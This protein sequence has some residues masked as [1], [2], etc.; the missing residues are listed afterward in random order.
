MWET[1]KDAMWLSNRFLTSTKQQVLAL[2]RIP[3]T[4]SMAFWIAL[5]NWIDKFYSKLISKT[6][7]HTDGGDASLVECNEYDVILS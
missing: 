5:C 4:K 7:F 6:E 3:M 1:Q 2:G